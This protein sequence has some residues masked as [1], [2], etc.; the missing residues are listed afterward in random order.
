VLDWRDG[1]PRED[2]EE[3]VVRA[4]L[5]AASEAEVPDGAEIAVTLVDD[6]TIAKY[7]A[8]Y[9]GVDSSTDVL[10]FPQSG[11]PKGPGTVGDGEASAYGDVMISIE[12]A[13]RQARQYGHSLV[14]EVALLAAHGVLHL[15]GYRDDSEDEAD[16]MREAER[17]A[18]DSAGYQPAR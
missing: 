7:N 12:T 3:A 2:L 14:D 18:L 13:E 8:R 15:A 17:R 9:R 11:G 10:A 16:R 5:A 4:G 6:R 1:S